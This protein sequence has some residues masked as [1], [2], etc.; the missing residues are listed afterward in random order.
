VA[1]SAAVGAGALGLG[2]IVSLAAT[3]AAADVTGILMAG[4]IAAVGFFILPARRRRAKEVMR[5]KVTAVREKLVRALR[6]E[7]EREMTRGRQRIE[8]AIAPYSRFVRA[9]HGKLI[10][11]RGELEGIAHEIRALRVRIEGG[12]PAEAP[13]S[14]G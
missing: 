5:A 11:M 10:A 2:A 8:G 6:A 13:G 3:S 12:G 9:E 14:R 1:A 7:F 4:V